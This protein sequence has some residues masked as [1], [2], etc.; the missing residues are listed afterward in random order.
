MVLRR[1]HHGDR[2]HDFVHTYN[3]AGEHTVLLIA[4]DGFG[5]K[6]TWTQLDRHGP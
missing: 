2:S 4:D 5:G 1:R 6:S 3:E